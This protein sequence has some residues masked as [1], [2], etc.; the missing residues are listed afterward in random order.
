MMWFFHIENIAFSCYGYPVSY[1]EA[2]AT[3]FG[4]ISVYLASRAHVFTWST[5][6]VNEFFLSLVFF[7]VQLYADVLLQVYFFV[8]SVYGW[9][10][11]NTLKQH[12][13]K[14]KMELKSVF[15]LLALLAFA[16]A[17]AGYTVARL[18]VLLPDYVYIPAAYPYTDSFI[19]VASIMA[20]LLL[21]QRRIEN[22]FL[23]IAIDVVCV[24]LYYKKEIYFLSLE[25][26]IFLGMATYGY[27]HWKTKLTHD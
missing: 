7:Q 13:I 27:F 10:H 20:T 19:M 18:H 6:I 24:M 15:G 25:Y 2:I 4:L 14:N 8:V 26:L 11:W 9:C 22:W 1:V 16:T 5:G 3:L 17:I 21:A 12:T 23:W